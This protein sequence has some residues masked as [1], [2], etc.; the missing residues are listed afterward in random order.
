MGC[1]IDLICDKGAGSS[2]LTKPKRIEEISRAM[3]SVL[4]CPLTLKM[5]KGFMDDH[6]VSWT[7]PA[8]LDSHPARSD[9]RSCGRACKIIVILIAW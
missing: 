2:L 3:S 7:L 6:D 4:S 1:P 8:W 5:R 9:P